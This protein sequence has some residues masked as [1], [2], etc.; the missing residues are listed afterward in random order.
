MLVAALSLT[1]C[2][3]HVT[4]QPSPTE[5][6]LDGTWVGYFESYK[7]PSGSDRITLTLKTDA[8]GAVTGTIVFGTS[9]PPPPP[10]NP[11][12][13]YPV[14]LKNS[15]RAIP[16]VG[17][18][19]P[20]TVLTGGTAYSRVLLT[21]EPRELWKAWCELQTSYLHDHSLYGC[22]P[23]SDSYS[24]CG[25]CWTA[26]ASGK[27]TPVDCGKVLLCEHARVCECRAS[28]CTVPLTGSHGPG[29]F[30]LDLKLTGDALDGSTSGPLGDELHLEKNVHFT[31]AK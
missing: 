17:D 29:G 21:I 7:L 27:R 4:E 30:T 25:D 5:P 3:G 19:F 10:T 6:T 26:D 20:F 12:I 18:G 23:P 1:A 2:G 22:L 15:S 28:G 9:A 24:C 14:G 11:N 31:R 16:F 13:G 8:T